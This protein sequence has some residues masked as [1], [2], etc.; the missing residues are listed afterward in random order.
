MWNV[1]VTKIIVYTLQPFWP[2]GTGIGRGFL[3]AFDAAWM[4]KRFL[5]G[6][7]PVELLKEREAGMTVLPHCSTTSIQK[8]SAKFT[9]DPRTRYKNFDTLSPAGDVS[10]LYDL[11]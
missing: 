5:A 9:I 11:Q 1:L 4:M 8:D 7:D 10:H 6:V 3:G 2:E